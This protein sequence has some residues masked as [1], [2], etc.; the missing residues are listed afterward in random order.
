MQERILRKSTKEFEAKKH[1]YLKELDAEM[2]T[3]RT[4]RNSPTNRFIDLCVRFIARLGRIIGG[5][6]VYGVTCLSVYFAPQVGPAIG[7]KPIGSLTINDLLRALVVGAV[8][9][10]GI[11]IAIKIVFDSDHEDDAACLRISRSSSLALLIKLVGFALRWTQRGASANARLH[12]KLF[13]AAV[14][15]GGALAER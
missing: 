12:A 8:M 14:A 7:D 11:Y 1:A 2:Q 3:L 10:A 13:E 4:L 15:N 6:L 5:A 9:L